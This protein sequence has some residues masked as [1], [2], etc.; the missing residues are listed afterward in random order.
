MADTYDINDQRTRMTAAPG[1]VFKRVT[2]ITYTTK[3]SGVIGVVT[4]D[5]ADPTVDDVDAAVTP[6][7]A[8]KERIAHL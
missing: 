8:E 6:A 3:P 2:D 5:T 4:L 7:A 1:G